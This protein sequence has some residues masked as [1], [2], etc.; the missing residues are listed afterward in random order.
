MLITDAQVHIWKAETPA[1][2][3]PPNINPEKPNGWT[4]AHHVRLMDELGIARAVIV[5][6]VWCG[7]ALANAY[8]IEAC[9]LFPD[10]YAI[11]ARF[12][13]HSS[14][15]R[16]RLANWLSQPYVYGIRLSAASLRELLEPDTEYGWFWDDCERLGIPLMI[17]IMDRVAQLRPILEK[18]PNLTIM[19]DHMATH[20]DKRGAD[21]FGSHKELL[22]LACF[23]NV[24]VKAS[25]LQQLSKDP[26]PY[27]D[28][29]PSLK[30]AWEAFGPRRYLWG[31]NVTMFDCDYAGSLRFF[32]EALDFIPASEMEWV[33][34]KNVSTLMKWP[35]K[36]S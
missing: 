36:G 14:N 9:E 23:P 13:Q 4:A 30:S 8:G 15:A 29:H 35:E 6:P 28:L 32:Q 26:Y 11:M 7:D 2:A 25:G 3:W 1:T 17:L 21:A 10:R 22:D 16:E 19:I 24:A 34:G 27:R 12:D 5:P 33:L 18:H 31:A 20:L